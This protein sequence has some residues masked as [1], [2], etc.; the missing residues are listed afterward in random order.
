MKLLPLT[1][2]IVPLLTGCPELDEILDNKPN[3]DANHS[4]AATSVRVTAKQ[5]H[6][7]DCDFQP[8]EICM[9]DE[10]GLYYDN[11][12]YQAVTKE[13]YEKAKIGDAK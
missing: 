1:L 13:V 9:P 11:N 5:F 4:T 8:K 2:I 3:P 6:K 12:T 10:Y 7:G